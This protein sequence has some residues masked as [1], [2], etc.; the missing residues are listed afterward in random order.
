MTNIGTIDRVARFALGAALLL[1]AFLPAV[2]NALGTWRW[3]LA[4]AG[5]VAIVTAAVRICPAYLL[6]GLRTCAIDR[7]KS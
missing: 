4:A 2:E 5:L 3:A 1:L 7:K 6:F